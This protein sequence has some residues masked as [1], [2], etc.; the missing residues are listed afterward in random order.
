MRVATV[1][2][3]R[4]RSQLLRDALAAVGRQ[5]RPPDAIFVVDNASS[6]DT[7]VVVRDQHP[8]VIYLP[9]PDNTGSGP[10]LAV[11]MRA[12]HEA[13]FD[14]FWLMDD[15]SQAAPDALASLL[16]ISERT[17]SPTG[18]IGFHGGTVRGGRIRHLTG[19]MLRSCPQPVPGAFKV[20]FVLLDGSLVLR[21][22]VDAV[23]VPRADFFMMMGDVEYPYRAHDARLDVLVLEH[24]LMDRLHAGSTGRPAPWRGYYQ[25]RNHLRWALDRRSPVL[26]AGWARRQLGFFVAA[27]RAPDRRARLGYRLRGTRDA[28]R[29]RMGR[30]VEPS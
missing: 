17:S 14:A 28:L 24:D 13:G 21:T 12:A 10:G 7:A 29:R 3:T 30:T 26:I 19:P 6:D 23:G 9:Q 2:V 11:G 25:A 20:D 16:S 15:D 22:M 1:I 4:N 5:T 8:D 27:R 18:I